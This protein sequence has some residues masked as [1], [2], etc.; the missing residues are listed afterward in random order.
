MGF[1]KIQIATFILCFVILAQPIASI[2]TCKYVGSCET[3]AECMSFCAA[4]RFAGLKTIFCGP[5][6][7]YPRVPKECCCVVG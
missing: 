3:Q 2:E 5:G 6:P 4:N 7:R 1:E